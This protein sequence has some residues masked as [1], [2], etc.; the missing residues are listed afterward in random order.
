MWCCAIVDRHGDLHAEA[1]KNR[2][3]RDQFAFRFIRE[4]ADEFGLRVGKG[5]VEEVHLR[6]SRKCAKWPVQLRL[7][8]GD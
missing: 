8:D 5:S 3:A 2:N 1:F 7:I 4:A 6:L